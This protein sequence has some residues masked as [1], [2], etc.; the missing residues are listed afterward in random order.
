MCIGCAPAVPEGRL[1]ADTV[2]SCVRF[3]RY[4]IAPLASV[5]SATAATIMKGRLRFMC[6]MSGE[7]SAQGDN[8]QAQRTAIREYFVPSLSVVF[9]VR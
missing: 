8:R 1:L 9:S 7:V 3:A 5:T 6:E 2:L 4:N